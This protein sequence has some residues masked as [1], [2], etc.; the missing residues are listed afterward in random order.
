MVL[1]HVSVLTLG[2]AN[3]LGPRPECNCVGR[4]LK[5][6]KAPARAGASDYRNT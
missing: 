1:I 5:I 2:R 4:R 6:P 3:R